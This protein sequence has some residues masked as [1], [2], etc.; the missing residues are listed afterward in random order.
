M[1]M[2]IIIIIAMII[3]TTTT[4]MMM[5]VESTREYFV[6]QRLFYNVRIMCTTS[7]EYWTI[8]SESCF[9]SQRLP[10]RPRFNVENLTE[11]ECWLKFRFQKNDLGRLGQEL[12]S[13]TEIRCA[14][15]VVETRIN[16]LCILLRRLAYPSRYVDLWEV[17]GRHP[18]EL[19]VIFN[20]TLQ[21]IF[22]NKI[23][24]LQNI[25]N[26]SWMQMDNL[27]SYAEAVNGKGAALQTCIGFIDGTTRP[28]SRPS[29]N[30]RVT[31]SGH[32]RVHCLK[33]RSLVMPN[34]LIGHLFGPMEGRRHDAILL[35]ESGLLDQIQPLYTR[36]GRPFT[37]YGDPAYPIR[38]HIISP[39]RRQNPNQQ[40]QQFNISMSAVR[41]CVEWGFD[42]IVTNFAFC[43]FR[44]NLK[45]LLQPVA[46]YYMVAALLTNC[47]CCLYGNQTSRFIE[48]EPPTLEQ[49]LSNHL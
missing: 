10:R 15:G 4:T 6:V 39:N 22:N 35:R 11:E 31:F 5:I 49:Y 21:H 3:T 7:N 28:I 46:M 27:L 19:S 17:F 14:N 42:D 26:L 25:N 16:A 12:G 1:I 37:I 18:T 38:E 8:V 23:H 20:E 45:I 24:L 32:K 41:E 9:R 13:P 29:E 36:D 43:D 2:I 44:K 48:L 33:F 47:K 30:Q 40:E 34:G